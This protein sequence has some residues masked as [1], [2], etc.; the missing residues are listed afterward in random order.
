MLVDFW[1]GSSWSPLTCSYAAIANSS[2]M[3][4]HTASNGVHIT[5]PSCLL[6]AH[7]SDD[8]DDVTATQLA[9]D[10]QIEHGE[11][12]S[13]PFDLEFVR[14]DQTCLGRSGGVAP[15]TLPS[16]QGTRLRGVGVAFT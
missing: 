10:R 12:P 3:N 2:G 5:K 14:I 8:G 13:T 6:M 4:R 15:A 1:A 9:V 11:V 16:F 7:V